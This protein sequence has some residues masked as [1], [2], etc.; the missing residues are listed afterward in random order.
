MK[1][2]NFA[3]L[4]SPTTSARLG[5]WQ[6]GRSRPD[7]GLTSKQMARAILAAGKK[8]RG[9]LETPEPT[10]L[11]ARILRAGRRARNAS[12]SRPR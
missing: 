9:D 1:L 2:T 3:H 11:A 4:R 12:A 10:G 6:E 8:A 7:V 5:V